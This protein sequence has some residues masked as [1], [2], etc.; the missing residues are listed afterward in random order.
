MTFSWEHVSQKHLAVVN[1]IARQLGLFAESV[2]VVL[3][4]ELPSLIGRAAICAVEGGGQSKLDG[5]KTGLVPLVSQVRPMRGPMPQ[6]PW[7]C[8][9]AGVESPT[10]GGH[11][12]F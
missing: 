8:P 5:P 3:K 1:P 10:Q 4:V 12:V 6:V 7:R 11:G 2:A 9:S